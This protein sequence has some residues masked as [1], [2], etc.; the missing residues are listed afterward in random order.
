MTATPSRRATSLGINNSAPRLVT[1]STFLAARE[2]LRATWQALPE[3]E[4]PCFP[5]R[6]AIRGLRLQGAMRA[7]PAR[8]DFQVCLEAFLDRYGLL[9][10]ATWELPDPA[11]PLLDGLPKAPHLLAGRPVQIAVPAHFRLLGTDDLHG[12]V[13]DLQRR[14]TQA[15]G[16]DPSCVGPRSVETYARLFEIDHYRGIADG[17]YGHSP[18]PKGYVN[19]L[20]E[21]LATY[22]DISLDHFRM[23]HRALT[24]FLRGEPHTNRWSNETSP[25]SP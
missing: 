3:A 12:L 5:L 21:A 8:T 1:D 15:A 4:R 2:A 9:N 18:R 7:S 6:R 22:L 19:R 11:A 13:Q 14:Q 20:H 23:L 16:L 25:Q 10:M 17:R 24:G